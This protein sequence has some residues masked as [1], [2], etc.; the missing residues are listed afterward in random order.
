MGISNKQTW[1][2]LTL[3]TILC[4]AIISMFL[5][6]NVFANEQKQEKQQSTIVGPVMQN[7]YVHYTPESDEAK[8]KAAATQKLLDQGVFTAVED[9]RVN[10]QPQSVKQK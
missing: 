5:G 4:V 2:T 9:S 8:A 1:N 6:G 10:Q 3:K 7:R